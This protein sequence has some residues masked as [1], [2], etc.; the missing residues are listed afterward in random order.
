MCIRDREGAYAEIET[1]NKST[2]Q[3]VPNVGYSSV[4]GSRSEARAQAYFTSRYSELISENAERFAGVKG[5][6]AEALE[7]EIRK[8]ALKETLEMIRKKAFTGEED[9]DKTVLNPTGDD[10]RIKIFHDIANGR[11]LTVGQIISY[12]K[13][14]S[15]EEAAIKEYLDNPTV[16]PLYYRAISTSKARPYGKLTPRQIVEAR[17]LATAHLRDG[18]Q[19]SVTLND[20]AQGSGLEEIKISELKSNPNPGKTIQIALSKPESLQWMLTNLADNY[21]IEPI[22]GYSGTGYDAVRHSI[23]T[24]GVNIGTDKPLTS[25][26]ISQLLLG[27]K[28]NPRY[29][30]GMYGMTTYDIAKE[31]KR[32][33]IR[34]DTQFNEQVQN[35]LFLGLVQNLANRQSEFSTFDNEWRRSLKLSE[36]EQNTFDAIIKNNPGNEWMLSEFN[37]L[38]QLLPACA[39]ELVIMCFQ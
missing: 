10:D 26:T 30:Y 5:P 3:F 12:N 31:V 4:I 1:V 16:V 9:I 7:N 36:K 38:N 32:Q 39:E 25:L 20:N 24:R 13:Y 27:H 23:P 17:V 18:S 22:N 6:E 11:K 19:P 15:H 35:Q 8:A 21:A 14:H 33:G 37:A 28:K 29:M 34:L 2:F